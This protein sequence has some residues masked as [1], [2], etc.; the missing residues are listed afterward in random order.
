MS[1]ARPDMSFLHFGLQPWGSSVCHHLQSVKVSITCAMLEEHLTV[2]RIGDAEKRPAC[3]LF[4]VSALIYHVRDR[5]ATAVCLLK[6]M[7]KTP[8][9]DIDIT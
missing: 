2:R 5:C 8:V 3:R 7:L 4:P 1:S 9:N 6:A